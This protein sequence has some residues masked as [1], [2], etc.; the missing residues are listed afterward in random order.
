MGWVFDY[1]DELALAH[2][3]GDCMHHFT[4]YISRLLCCLGS[5]RKITYGGTYRHFTEVSCASRYGYHWLKVCFIWT[6]RPSSWVWE[7]LQKTILWRTDES[8][9]S[10]EIENKYS[11]SVCQVAEEWCHEVYNL[12]EPEDATHGTWQR[13]TAFAT[14]RVWAFYVHLVFLHNLATVGV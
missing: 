12:W 3:L 7:S 10:P 13:R 5:I 1:I 14:S 2:R 9:V 8:L 4:L 11:S 6:D